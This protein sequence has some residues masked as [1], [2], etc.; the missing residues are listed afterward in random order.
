MMMKVICMVK[1]IKL[2]N[3][4]PKL[5]ATASGAAPMPTAPTATTATASTANAKASGN[6]RSAQAQQRSATADSSEPSLAE[7]FIGFS[8]VRRMPSRHGRQSA[9][10]RRRAA[11]RRSAAAHQASTELSYSG[12]D[13]P[14]PPI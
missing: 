7:L 11:Q 2:Q 14:E 8:R 10:H 3:P 13:I 1:G 12:R 5:C 6:Q 9:G 4:E